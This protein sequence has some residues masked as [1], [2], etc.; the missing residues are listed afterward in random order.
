VIIVDNHRGLEN[1]RSTAVV[2]KEEIKKM[3][4]RSELTDLVLERSGKA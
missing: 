4:D 3:D 2:T 1:I